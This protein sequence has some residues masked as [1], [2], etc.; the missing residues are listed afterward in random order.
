MDKPT[1]CAEC[2]HATLPYWRGGCDY[3]CQHPEERIGFVGATT[4]FPLCRAVNTD[5]KCPR[6]AARPVRE[7]LKPGGVIYV[8]EPRPWWRR[9]FS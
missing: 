6:F 9:L 2:A 8:T 4:D 1:I 7:A 5:G 3:L